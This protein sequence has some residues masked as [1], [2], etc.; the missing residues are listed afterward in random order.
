MSQPPVSAAVPS[1]AARAGARLVAILL[2][3]WLWL[4][5][6]GLGVGSLAWNLVAIA[7][8]P[9]LPPELGR[10]VGRAGIA[11]GYRFFW[12]CTRL[13][14]LVRI[15]ATGLD[16]LAN[17]TRGLIIAANHPSALDAL[18]IIAYLPRAFCVMKASLMRNP[19]LGAGARLAR[20]VANDSPRD[21]LQ[22]AVA[23]VR[24]G[25]QLVLFPEGTRTV[26]GRL[27]HF[28]PG[29]TSISQRA[30]AP[31]QTV[32]IE[33][34]SPYLG[35]G[36]PIWKSPPE[37]IVFRLRLGRRFEPDPDPQGQLKQLE[38]YFRREL[39]G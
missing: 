20:Y 11:Y 3:P 6:L 8:N 4:Y 30:D 2:G 21:M 19:C 15:D 37:P 13:G 18:A 26:G 39:G 17:E 22:V 10:R 38:A 28:L 36:W 23:G 24:E 32:I 25:G 29:V 33:T 35:K 1:V 14:N 16:T 9:L 34:D 7:L 12:F 27:N 5:L 31:I